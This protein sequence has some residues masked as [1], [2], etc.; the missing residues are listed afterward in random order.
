MK[1]DWWTTTKYRQGMLIV[2]VF[3]LFL[4]FMFNSFSFFLFLLISSNL[5]GKSLNY[6]QRKVLTFSTSIKDNI[7]Y[8]TLFI[9]ET[10]FPFGTVLSS[11]FI[12]NSILLKLCVHRWFYVYEWYQKKNVAFV[13][14]LTRT[15]LLYF[16]HCSWLSFVSSF[17]CLLSL[18]I[19]VFVVVVYSYFLMSFFR[20]EF[21]LDEWILTSITSITTAAT[22]TTR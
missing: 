15:S 9:T 14:N 7:S 10:F 13:I 1:F 8:I 5:I 18:F 20:Y 11:V 22:T 6:I 21:F 19:N 17:Y 16:F 2:L 4:L 3:F 12:I